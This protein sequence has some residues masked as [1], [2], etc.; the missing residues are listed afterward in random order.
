[1]PNHVRNILTINSLDESEVKAVLDYLKGP[2]GLVDFNSIVP[3]PADVDWYSW[4]IANWGTKWNAYDVDF[5]GDATLEFTTAWSG[6]DGLVQLVSA[7]FPYIELLYSWADE[8]MGYNV[9][10]CSFKGG[11]MRDENF[12]EEGSEAALELAESIW[13]IEVVEVNGFENS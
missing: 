7:K 2:N 8:D 11:A 5:D 6:V 4:R 9:G 3:Q 12:P 13:N 10:E 1:M